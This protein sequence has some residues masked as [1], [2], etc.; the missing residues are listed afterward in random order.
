MWTVRVF[1]SSMIAITSGI[2]TVLILG[3]STVGATTT[4]TS[5]ITHNVAGA[6][7]SYG[8]NSLQ[9]VY[10]AQLAIWYT[11]TGAPSGVALQEVCHN[12]V[13][14]DWTDSYQYLRTELLARG[15]QTNVVWTKYLAS[16]QC[17]QGTM[18]A[19]KGSLVGGDWA[20]LPGQADGEDRVAVCVV[21]Q[22]Y[23]QIKNCSGHL[24]T[25]AGQS[26]I[27]SY[28]YW[29]FSNSYAPSFAEWAGGDFNTDNWYSLYFWYNSY[30]EGDPLNRP[31]I[32]L[33]KVDY[34]FGRLP[35]NRATGGAVV[36]GRGTYSD[37]HLISSP[38]SW[39]Y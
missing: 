7:S 14:P 23:V 36:T 24:T 30:S 1:R 20:L 22:G 13:H 10:N 16:L 2:A 18:V 11:A 39:V 25:Y 6:N 17:Q 28:A 35:L 19:G 9:R 3:V 5:Y 15:Y 8:Q 27:Q 37:H 26:D 29:N 38:F 33:K 12:Y 4:P 32:A 21:T 31:T 34:S